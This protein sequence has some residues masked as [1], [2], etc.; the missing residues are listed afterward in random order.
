ML[1]IAIC[2]DDIELCGMIE[3]RILGLGTY[4][5]KRLD[6]VVFYSGESLLSYLRRGEQFDIIYLDIELGSLRGVEIGE[7]IRNEKKDESVQIIYI[8]GSDHYAMELFDTRPMN[9]LIKPIQMERF[10]QVF[11]KACQLACKGEE[12]FCYQINQNI[13]RQFVKEILYFECLAK[14]IRMVLVSG[15]KCF[16][17]RIK[18]VEKQVIKLGFA[19]IHKSY[20]I[21]LKLVIKHEYHQVTMSDGTVLP[22]AQ[23]KRS[24]IRGLLIHSKT[25]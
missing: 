14:K 16:Y 12:C 3:T 10:D 9:F 20:I 15:E 1:R 25:E 11:L 17:S 13:Y 19:K 4:C 18:E 24:E 21:N 22:I 6:V 7:W 23:S 8:S 2:D 5:A